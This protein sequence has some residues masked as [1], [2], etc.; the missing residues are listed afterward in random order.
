MPDLSS[1]CLLGCLLL[2]LCVLPGWAQPSPGRDVHQG[3]EV[4]ANEVLMKFRDPDAPVTPGLRQLHDLD[5]VTGVAGG[6]AFLLRS[7]SKKVA[8][9]IQGLSS[10]SDVLS[11]GGNQQHQRHPGR[12]GQQHGRADRDRA[13]SADPAVDHSQ[14]R[15]CFD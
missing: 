10:R 1:R 12:R 5:L 2:T 13:A 6:R 7:R 3:H 8:Q 15:E 9:L 4:M 14:S 11:S